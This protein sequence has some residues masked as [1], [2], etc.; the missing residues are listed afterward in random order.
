MTTHRE[1]LGKWGSL[2]EVAVDLGLNGTTGRSRV[3]GWYSRNK[4]PSRY[5][6]PLVNAA[7]ARQIEGVSTDSLARAIH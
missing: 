1:M 2:R 7:T 4:I 6:I 5:W 3:R